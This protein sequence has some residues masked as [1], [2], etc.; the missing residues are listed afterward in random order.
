ML[1]YADTINTTT[2]GFT[3]HVNADWREATLDAIGTYSQFTSGGS[4]LQ[5]SILFARN[6]RIK[7]KLLYEIGGF[8]GGSAHDDGS[9]TGQSLGATVA[10]ESALG[11]GQSTTLGI[12]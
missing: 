11:E 8:T 6:F 2:F 10:P 5:G 7:E 4:A 1:R 3:P 12:R 9:R